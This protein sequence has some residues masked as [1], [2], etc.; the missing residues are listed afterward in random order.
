MLLFSVSQK[1]CKKLLLK[2]SFKLFHGDLNGIGDTV[3]ISKENF[4]R[5]LD[6]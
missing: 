1:E 6:H 2:H 4:E 3:E 5:P